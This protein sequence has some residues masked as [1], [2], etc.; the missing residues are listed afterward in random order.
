MNWFSVWVPAD[1]NE[2]KIGCVR[3]TNGV[4]NIDVYSLRL[5]LKDDPERAM[6]IAEKVLKRI[7][8][9]G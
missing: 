4:W 5:E 2:S 8:A 9:A 1:Q 6:A 7:E 3:L